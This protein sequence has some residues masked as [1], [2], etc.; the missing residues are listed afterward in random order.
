MKRW[1][2]NSISEVFINLVMHTHNKLQTQLKMK[3]PKNTSTIF[4][5]TKRSQNK[6][7]LITTQIGC[8][9]LG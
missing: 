6:T 3:K 5:K 2:H 1:L 9:H 7:Q 8:E 4:L